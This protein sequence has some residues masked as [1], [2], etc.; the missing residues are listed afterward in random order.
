MKNFNSTFLVLYMAGLFAN[1]CAQNGN[2]AS[3]STSSSATQTCR[4]YATNLTD[5]T[6][7]ITFSCTFNGSTTVSCTNGGSE[8]I[9]FTYPD[10]QTFVNEAAA[11]VSIFNKPRYTS[12]VINSATA[13]LKHNFTYTYDTSGKLT[14]TVDNEMPSF[15]GTYTQTA[16]DTNN[17]ATAVTASYSGGVTCS[18]RT[19]TIAYNDTT[20]I[21]TWTQTFTG[22][23]A[24][25][26]SIPAACNDQQDANGN[27]VASSLCRNFTVNATASACY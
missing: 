15:T 13:T 3:N 20:R 27:P 8:T 25:C 26:A 12:L 10:L 19:Y 17:R 14:S 18:N 22:T 6:N 21:A 5:T 7:S 1:G 23:G 24:N 4:K 11:P 9:V 2:S 16:W